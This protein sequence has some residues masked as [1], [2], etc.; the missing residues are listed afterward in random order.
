MGLAC[1]P[2]DEECRHFVGRGVGV[3]ILVRGCDLPLG[4]L[5]AEI[6]RGD[7]FWIGKVGK[8]IRSKYAGVP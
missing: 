5:G 4:V 8:K 1:F 2:P 7:S 3:D 6:L